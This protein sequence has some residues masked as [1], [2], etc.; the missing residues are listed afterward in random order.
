MRKL[1]LFFCLFTTISWSQNAK[2]FVDSQGEITFFS[3]TSVE[4]IKASN[5]Q[6]VSIFA[7]ETNQL[8]VKILMRAFVFEKALMEEHF[9][10]SYIE[11]DLFPNAIFQGNVIDFDSISNLQTKK[12]E[13]EFTMHGVT[14][15]ISLRA[16]ILKS[17]KTFQFSGTFEVAVKD[18][19]IK[20]PALLAPNIAETISVGFNFQYDI[21]EK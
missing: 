6:V 7:P 14:K 1:L 11:S 3:Y 20:I 15:E 4:N 12:I 17:D 16:K 19:D 2:Q 21:Y 10:E 8:V 18:Y 5:N 13:G 9:N